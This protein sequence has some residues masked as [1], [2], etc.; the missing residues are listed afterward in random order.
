[1]LAPTLLRMPL[2]LLQVL[3]RTNLKEELDLGIIEI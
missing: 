3:L 1:M 2:H